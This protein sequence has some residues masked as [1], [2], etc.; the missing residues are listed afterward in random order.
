MRLRHALE[1]NGDTLDLERSL[2]EQG[3]ASEAHIVL[4]SSP[5]MMPRVPSAGGM[6]FRHMLYNEEAMFLS[7]VRRRL[8]ELLRHGALEE[9]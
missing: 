9:D 2:S 5:V 1:H 6:V 8:R 4:C 3:I 7:V